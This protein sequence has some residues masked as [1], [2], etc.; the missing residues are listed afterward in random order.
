MGGRLAV[1]S[2]NQRESTMTHAPTWL[3]QICSFS[4][5]MRDVEAEMPAKQRGGRRCS[6]HKR[7]PDC[8]NEMRFIRARC[9][10]CGHEFPQRAQSSRPCPDCGALNVAGADNC[11]ACGASLTLSYSLTL[12]E[13]LRQGPL[14]EVPITMR[15]KFK[16][17][18]NSRPEFE[19][20]L[21]EAATFE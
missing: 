13:A 10:E 16:R 8:G 20:W 9:D 21:F 11:H 1:S 4:M 17:V 12:D 18:N 7:C 14:S 15:V 3:C 5:L 6:R 19:L 2:Q